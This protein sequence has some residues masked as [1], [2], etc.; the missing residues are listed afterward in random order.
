MLGA[1]KR[2]ASVAAVAL[3]AEMSYS[4]WFFSFG[5]AAVLEVLVLVFLWRAVYAGDAG[6]TLPVAL[7]EML[8]YVCVARIVHQFTYPTGQLPQAIRSGDISVLFLRP[9]DVQLYYLSYHLGAILA[10]VARI[11]LPMYVAVSLIVGPVLPHS[12]L[13]LAQF[14]LSL[15]ASV[16]VGFLINFMTETLSFWTLNA[17]GIRAAREATI[18]LL[19]GSTVPLFVFPTWLANVVGHLPF[20]STVYVP[21]AI[22]AGIISG[23]AAWQAILGQL[24][25]AV[26]LTF[27]ARGLWRAA[28]NR[29]IVQGG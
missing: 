10:E 29:V 25:W 13:A 18:E 11:A 4:L 20:A 3:K 1:V 6:Q 7:G 9:A 22:F 5:F 2:Y 24:A 23:T 21:T 17:W 16:V 19:S 8:T 26:V 28:T 12:A 27:L 14:V 15:A